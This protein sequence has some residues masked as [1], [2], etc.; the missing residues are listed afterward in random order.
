MGVDSF[1]T[2]LSRFAPN[3]YFQVPLTQFAGK[4][5]SV[6]MANLVY[7]MYK[8]AVKQVLNQT[9]LNEAGPDSAAIDRL[10]L[11]KV[12][13]KLTTFMSYDIQVICCFDSAPNILK[14]RTKVK[15]QAEHNKKMNEYNQ[16]VTTFFQTDIL[17]RRP[18]VDKLSRS[19]CGIMKPSHEFMTFVR[20]TLTSLGFVTMLAGDY[21]SQTGDA[22]ALCASL[23]IAGNDYCIAALTNDSDFHT[24]GGNYS[25]I[26][27]E[28]TVI[29]I[30][31]ENG[32]PIRKQTHVAKVRSLELILSSLGVSFDIFRDI[33][34]MLG[35]D[36]NDHIPQVGPVKVIQ[37]L[38][39]H[40][41]LLNVARE[42]DITPYNYFNVLPIFASTMIRLNPVRLDFDVQAFKEN[43][44][45]IL[46]NEQ[47]RSYYK[48]IKGL[49]IVSGVFG[50]IQIKDQV[51]PSSIGTEL[52]L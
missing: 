37:L 27:I 6:D 39:K 15:R 47:L 3:V 24:Y 41:C 50:S 23:C 48:T 35:T 43:G 33:C 49:P 11:A 30:S 5:I 13:E 2:F 8:S 28:S 21:L 52:V 4:R 19:I 25:I 16:L 31:D 40:G 14:D 12:L 10:T 1:S 26:E 38:S 51:E 36:Y 32:Y 7:V 45:A 17:L 34:I 9:N 20:N 42:K 22:E 46:E 29:Q 44:S 18:L